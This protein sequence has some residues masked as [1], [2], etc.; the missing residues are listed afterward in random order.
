[1][2]VGGTFGGTEFD[3]YKKEKYTVYILQLKKESPNYS[4]RLLRKIAV[5]ISPSNQITCY[6]VMDNLVDILKV[7]KVTNTQRSLYKRMI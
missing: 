5:L 2:V 3:K 7:M 4:N 1:M 6:D